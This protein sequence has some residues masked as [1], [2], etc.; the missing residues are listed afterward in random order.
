MRVVP[1]GIGHG[2]DNRRP[3]ALVAIFDAEAE[4]RVS[5]ERCCELFGFTPAE[6]QVAIGIMNG[7]SIEQIAAA[8]GRSLATSR[9]L[10]KRAFAKTGVKRQSELTY[11]MLNSPLFY[12]AAGA[13]APRPRL[14]SRTEAR[15]R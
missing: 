15:P 5:V 6:A 7:K 11:L 1:L 8:Q 13:A 2:R 12:N 9:N 3:A 14:R 4:L 10:L